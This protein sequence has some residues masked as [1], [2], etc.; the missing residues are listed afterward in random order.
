MN[1]RTQNCPT[2]LLLN[3]TFDNFDPIW[4]AAHGLIISMLRFEN[5]TTPL[6]DGVLRCEH[7]VV[8]NSRF[9]NE[10]EKL[11]PQY[12]SEHVKKPMRFTV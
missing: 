11:R 10:R 12:G 1:L 3:K 6:N 8:V 7:T 5:W 2:N 4:C 9:A